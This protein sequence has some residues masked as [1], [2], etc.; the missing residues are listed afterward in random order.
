MLDRI[1]APRDRHGVANGAALFQ[2]QDL[3]LDFLACVQTRRAWQAIGCRDNNP[4]LLQSR[5]GADSNV[6]VR[7]GA[8][9]YTVQ[10]HECGGIM[11]PG[12]DRVHGMRT[13]IAATTRM[14]RLRGCSGASAAGPKC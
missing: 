4:S 10:E 2:F 7:I 12:R 9:P 14:E 5:H 13:G 1:G 6:A 3:W 11:A 8:V